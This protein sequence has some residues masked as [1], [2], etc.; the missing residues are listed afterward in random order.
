MVTC[1]LTPGGQLKGGHD[2]LA[3]DQELYVCWFTNR[4]GE[5]N[6]FG[7]SLKLI[8]MDD[9][10]IKVWGQDGPVNITTI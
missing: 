6:R 10:M 4:R 2:G 5:I 1:I 9:M 3:P 7:F 8:W